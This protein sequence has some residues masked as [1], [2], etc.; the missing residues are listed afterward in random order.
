MKFIDKGAFMDS[1]TIENLLQKENIIPTIEWVAEQIPGGFFVYNAEEPF[2]LLFVNNIVLRMFGC[3]TRDEFAKLTGGTFRG[4]VHPEDFDEIQESIDK[5]ISNEKN[6]NLDYVEYRII[7]W[8]GT[9]RWVD[10]YSHFANIPQY[11]NVYYVFISDIT[12]KHFNQKDKLRHAN[13]YQ[14]MLSQFQELSEN[15]LSVMRSNTSK[16]ILEDIRGTDLYPE[17]K[18]GCPIEV[19]ANLRSS[20]FIMQSDRDKYMETFANVKLLTERYYKGLGPATMIGFCRRHSGFIGFVKFSA[21]VVIDPITKNIIGF[22]METDYNKEYILDIVSQK[23]LARQYDLISYIVEDTYSVII[24]ND[25]WARKGGLTQ[26]RMSGSYSKVLDELLQ[27]VPEEMRDKTAHA[28][29][30]ETVKA[31]MENHDMYTVDFLCEA[32]G[33]FY[34]KRFTFY[35]A[36]KEAGIYILLQNDISDIVRKEYEMNMIMSNALREAERANAAKTLFLSNMSHEIRTPMNA[37]VGLDN[38]ALQ[39]P[40]LPDQVRGYLEKIGASAKHLLSIINDI[41]DMSRIESGRITVKKEDFSFSS[42]LEQINTI[43]QAQCSDKGLTYECR[44]IGT[45]N[46]RYIGDDIKIK[47]V[48]INILGNAVKFTNAPGSVTLTIE[49]TALF[50]N[51][52]TLRFIISD[53][54]IGMDSSF[55]PKIFD[56]FS[57]ENSGSNNKY[58]STGLGMAITKNIVEMMNGNITVESEKGVGSKFTVTITLTNSQNEFQHISFDPRNFRV[59]IIDDDPIACQHAALVMENIGIPADTCT[60]YEDAMRM[61]ELSNAKNDPYNLIIVDWQMPDGD[62][63]TITKEFRQKYNN[64]STIIILTAYN[65]DDIMTEATEIGVDGF[66]SKPL[67]AGNMVSELEQIIQRKNIA[68]KQHKTDLAGKRVLLAEDIDI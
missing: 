53:T 43:I 39:L 26:E 25:E 11:G 32:E 55:L 42:L 59:L 40:N 10:D 51:N 15:S 8:D 54:G 33:Q 12:D 58:G 46:D 48:L 23:V 37:I 6:N 9:V 4:M 66:M 38:I 60:N 27:T 44:I 18:E 62:G 41:L 14:A 67:F 30:L 22:G 17:D 31:Y 36:N 16:G 3:Q 19:T 50:E 28:A 68:A 65:L 1:K 63:L 29:N 35:L 64:D 24:S 5:Q 52:A 20:S 49:Q 47:Q 56:A 45:M 61:T 34:N 7:R 2:N 13:A 21:S 57:Q